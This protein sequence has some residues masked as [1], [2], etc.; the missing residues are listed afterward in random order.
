MPLAVAA[1]TNG[2]RTE[3][4]PGCATLRQHIVTTVHQET[5]WLQNKYT[6]NPSLVLNF[7][8]RT[9]PTRDQ[10]LHICKS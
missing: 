8:T 4:A 5:H 10:R 1:V 9:T 6:N 7:H 2:N 3:T